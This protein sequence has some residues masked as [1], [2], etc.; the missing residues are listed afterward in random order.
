MHFDP[1]KLFIMCRQEALL[2]SRLTQLWQL[3]RDGRGVLMD[4]WNQSRHNGPNRAFEECTRRL[5][6]SRDRAWDWTDG[7]IAVEFH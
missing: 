4:S 1:L 3:L 7:C 5:S 6:R 2:R